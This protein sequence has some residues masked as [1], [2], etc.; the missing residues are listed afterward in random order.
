MQV[1]FTEKSTA[2]EGREGKV[3]NLKYS[4]LDCRVSDFCGTFRHLCPLGIWI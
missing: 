1:S 2:E 3:K 4:I